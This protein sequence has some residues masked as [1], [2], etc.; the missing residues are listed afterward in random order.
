MLLGGWR[1]HLALGLTGFALL[2]FGAGCDHS[3]P[4]DRRTA[5]LRVAEEVFRIFC[6]RVAHE[7][8]PEDPN[9]VQFAP[10]CE[11]A[12]LSFDDG[13]EQNDRL[14]ALL[15]RRAEAVAA[16][17]QMFGDAQTERTT[18]IDKTG[19]ELE[20]FLVQM[21]PY[22]TDEGDRLLPRST[23]A[24]ARVLA[25]LAGDADSSPEVRAKLAQLGTRMGYRSPAQ[26]LAALRPMLTYPEL[27]ALTKTL[28]AFVSEGEPA[29]DDFVALLEA[30]ALELAEPAEPADDGPS[31]LDLLLELVLEEDD[32]FV[33][34]AR[35]PLWV[36]R[37]DQRG[38]AQRREGVGATAATPFAVVGAESTQGTERDA[39]GRALGRDGEPLHVYFDANKTALAALLRDSFPLVRRDGQPRSTVEKLLRALP[40]LLG[41]NSDRSE[42]FG[43]TSYAYSGPNIAESPLADLV[44][45]FA[46]LAKYPETDELLAVVE[47]LLEQDEST[48]TALIHA[49]LELDALSDLPAYR[50]AQLTGADGQLG[51]PHELW[52][53]LIEIGQRVIARGEPGNGLLY[54]IMVASA[55]P[56]SAANGKL[57]GHLMHFKDDVKLAGTD[58][59]GPVTAGCGKDPKQPAAAGEPAFCAPVD[60]REPFSDRGMNRS[61]FQRIVSLI[62]ATYKVPNCNKQGATLSVTDPLPLTFPNPGARDPI[63]GG[64][65][66]LLCPFEGT[67]DSYARCALVEQKDGA[68]THMRSMLQKTKITLK[69][70]QL[71]CAAS[72]FDVD[73][74]EAQETNAG[75]EGFTLEPTPTAI[76]RYV[77][78]E[79]TKF[80]TDLFEPFPTRHGV[81]LTV[82]EPNGMYPLEVLD[83]EATVDGKPQSFLS[84]SVP[85]L[86]AFDKYETFDEAGDPDKGYLFA[87]LLALIHTHYPSPRK[88]LCPDPLSVQDAGCSQRLD[89]SKK[90][91]AKQSNLQSYEPLLTHALVE[92]DLLG[93]LQRTNVALAKIKVGP[94]DGPQRDGLQVV[95]RFLE[96]MLR[97]DETLRYRDGRS[98][99]ATSTCDVKMVDGKPACASSGR[100]V[101]GGIPPLYLLLDA[102]KRIDEAWQDDDARHQ[103]WLEARSKLVDQLL[104]VVDEGGGM[105]K[106]ENRTSRA[107]TLRALPWLRRRIAAHREQGDLDDWADGLVERLANVLGHPIGA[108]ALDL[109]EHFWADEAVGDQ[110]AQL[111]QYLLDEEAHPESFTGTLLALADTLELMAK[112]PELTPAIRFAA[113]TISPEAVKAVERTGKVELEIEE[114]TV[115]RMLEVTRAVADF[116]KSGTLST[117]AKL[118]HN[119]VVPLEGGDLPELSPKSPLEVLIDV[120]A[121]VNRAELSRERAPLEADEHK[122]VYEELNHFLTSDQNGLVR[123]Y[124]VIE[125]RKI[126]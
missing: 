10:A 125:Q 86:A 87:E 95:T 4:P 15:A 101:A 63:V 54:D 81:P 116:S 111:T 107:L 121:D 123:L 108:R 60:R 19:D 35:E 31:T 13:D 73:L 126:N 88:E 64:A 68:V 77:Y 115:Y 36:L 80:L 114:G 124:Q 2:G 85:L 97:S 58:K 78:A 47:Q 103:L 37:R 61:I 14:N 38:D 71:L 39:A 56:L 46:M 9:G 67:G 74:A 41:A 82:F 65:L 69:D 44:H 11:G 6:M 27:D 83:P 52:D 72:N 7:A 109:F 119:A 50:D 99:A 42:P 43:K 105:F 112:D 51:T 57:L 53:D 28:L 55:L 66:G 25:Q 96:R 29:H 118:L 40:P 93:I 79:R 62:D 49:A 18:E 106:L 22:Y 70:K 98:Y 34:P 30:S 26:V 113:L 117:I 76:A 21:L 20:N 92:L 89:P 8:H 1:S 12:V 102:L 110:V 48:A 91:Y 45:A 3:P 122:R 17:D 24:L 84:A 59:N 94:E 104:T 120:I 33:G 16:L 23:D 75:I 5:D 90:F 100:I 32:G